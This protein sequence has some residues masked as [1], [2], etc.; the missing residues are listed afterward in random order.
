MKDFELLSWSM[1]LFRIPWTS[2]V[3]TITHLILPSSLLLP[4]TGFDQHPQVPRTPYLLDGVRNQK[5]F[6]PNQNPIY[7][8]VNQH[9]ELK[10]A[11]RADDVSFLK[12]LHFHLS[13]I[14]SQ[15]RSNEILHFPLATTVVKTCDSGWFSPVNE[16]KTNKNVSS[17]EFSNLSI[18]ACNKN[19]LIPTDFLNQIPKS[20]QIE[21][22][23]Q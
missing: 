1:D 2:I 23:F 11:P 19:M 22:N 4:S 5:P 14:F 17:K 12:T 16:Q 15:K 13:Q 20:F 18:L 21:S 3:L 10:N 7:I 8:A 6:S 9:G